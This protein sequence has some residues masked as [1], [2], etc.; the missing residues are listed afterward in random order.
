MSWCPFAT[1]KKVGY[2]GG[3]YTG[4]PFRIVLHTTEG[5]SAKSA[6]DE[7]KTEYAPHFV[8]NEG[9]IY[10]LLDTSIAGAAMR[11]KGSPETNRLSAIQIEMVGFAG[12]PKNL[13]MLAN[14]ARLCRWI[15]AEHHVPQVWPNGLCVPAVNGKDGNKHNRSVEGWLKGGYFGHEHVPENVHWDPALTLEE[16]KIVT[17]NAFPVPAVSGQ[18]VKGTTMAITPKP[19]PAPEPKPI[20]TAPAPVV[21]PATDPAPFTALLQAYDG[22][23]GGHLSTL[24][25]DQDKA[26]KAGMTAAPMAFTMPDLKGGFCAS[27]TADKALLDGVKGFANWFFP[28]AAMVISALE[29]VG[30]QMY[31]SSCTVK[32]P[33]AP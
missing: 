4:G 9:A 19:A 26:V 33:P 29:A 15:E 21:A 3:A 1:N 13:A 25:S 23:K 27:W 5:S 24:K 16:T 8:V 30:D 2:N 11:H 20:A 17:P 12:K 31:K 28:G 22:A 14:V 7:F 18:T 32:T 10:Q 6:I